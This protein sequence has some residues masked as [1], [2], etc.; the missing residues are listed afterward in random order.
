M[1]KILIVEDD[2]KLR[3]ELEIFLTNSVMFFGS[4]R[5]ELWSGC[6]VAA[7]IIISGSSLGYIRA[8]DIT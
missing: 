8:T 6:L 7:Y 4:A 3:K 1:Q 5:L 2:E